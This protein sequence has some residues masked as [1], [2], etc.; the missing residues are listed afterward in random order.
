L[1]IALKALKLGDLGFD[2]LGSN[3]YHCAPMSGQ[4]IPQHLEPFKHIAA[5]SEIA[6]TIALEG[7]KGLEGLLTDFNGEVSVSLGFYRDEQNIA[8]VS[9]QIT[10]TLNLVCQRC[11]GAYPLG[12]KEEF[13]FALLRDE[14]QI[15]N[16]P[17]SYEP[18]VLEKP[19]LDIH[20]LVEQ[21]LILALPIVHYHESNCE[22]LSNETSFGDSGT[23]EL[24]RPNPFAVLEKLKS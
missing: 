11:L 8:L 10:S 21:E 19:E 3:P 7:L 24:K 5:G 16:L 20:G 18:L 12:V 2:T 17:E 14:E 1:S 22:A 9:G 23:E 6:G 13:L 15:E 4:Q